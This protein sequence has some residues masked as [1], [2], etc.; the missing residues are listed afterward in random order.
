MNDDPNDRRTQF[1]EFDAILSRV[2]PKLRSALVATYGTVDGREALGDALSWA[3]EH[4]ETVRR[5]DHPIGYLYRVGQTA[6]RRTRIRPIPA[7]PEQLARGPDEQPMSPHLA[8]AVNRLPD[9]QRRVVMLVNAFG[10]SQRDVRNCS[11]SPRPPSNK[12]S[13]AV[14]TALSPN[15]PTIR[16][17]PTR[18][19]MNMID[20][21]RELQELGARMLAVVPPMTTSEVLHRVDGSRGD[22]RPALQVPAPPRSRRTRRPTLTAAASLALVA[23]LGVALVTIGGDDTEHGGGSTPTS[24][25]AIAP[26]TGELAWPPR[27]MIE[28]DPWI[29][30]S[31]NETA[32]AEIESG[33]VVYQTSGGSIYMSY[34]QHPGFDIVP[35]ASKVADIEVLGTPVGVYGGSGE[36]VSTDTPI[37]ELDRFAVQADIGDVRYTFRSDGLTVDAFVEALS[38]LRPV[39]E[40]TFLAALP[41]GAVTADDRDR[42]LD[43]VLSGTPLPV[44]FDRASLG[45]PNAIVMLDGLHGLAARAAIEVTCAWTDRWFDAGASG[46]SAAAA[47]A[48]EALSTIRTWGL[49]SSLDASILNDFARITDAIVAGEDTTAMGAALNRENVDLALQCAEG[50]LAAG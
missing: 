42:W 16:R 36:P 25:E 30:D 35:G 22:D 49:F 4:F 24:T 45:N 41:P 11:A 27:L 9:Q 21:D 2:E 1:D 34:L 44:G 6:T 38:Q 5:M 29:L 17:P 50:Q 37:D 48:I 33:E 10:W 23:G 31:I 28:E 19:V 47:D 14:S 46:D 8:A 13:N 12:P 40:A 26:P 18:T 15:S 32:H 43:S 20:L 39:D 3:W 7:P